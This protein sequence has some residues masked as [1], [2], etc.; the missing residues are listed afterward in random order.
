MTNY[1]DS[2]YSHF[3]ITEMDIKYSLFCKFVYLHSTPDLL[4]SIHPSIHPSLIL[5]CLAWK[6][7][8]FLFNAVAYV[9]MAAVSEGCLVAA[10]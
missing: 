5:P 10:R 6:I 7:A 2:C 8:Q 9:F 3:V 1:T 4:L